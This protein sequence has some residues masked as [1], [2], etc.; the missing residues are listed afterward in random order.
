M[1]LRANLDNTS[2]YSKSFPFPKIVLILNFLS[3][4]SSYIYNINYPILLES[5]KIINKS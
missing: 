2:F 4:K 3:K 5:E 1:F